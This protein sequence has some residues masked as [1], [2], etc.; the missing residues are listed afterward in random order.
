M[1]AYSGP[2]LSKLAIYPGLSLTEHFLFLHIC[3]EHG[4]LSTN[5]RPVLQ[6][7][8]VVKIQSHGNL[9]SVRVTQLIHDICVLTDTFAE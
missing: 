6:R 5:T 2:P 3:I 1:P 7:E 9:K 4:S 8:G